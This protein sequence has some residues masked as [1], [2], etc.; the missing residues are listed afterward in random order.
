[1]AVALF[2]QET[3]KTGVLAAYW[4]RIEPFVFL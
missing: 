3:P 4:G 1:M 2:P